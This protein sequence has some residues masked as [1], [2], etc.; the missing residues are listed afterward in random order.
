MLA[1][2][3]PNGTGFAFSR[4]GNYLVSGAED[5]VLLFAVRTCQKIKE[6]IGHKD[7]VQGLTFTPD[8]KTVVSSSS[9]QTI[10]LWDIESGNEIKQFTITQGVPSVVCV[11]NCGKLL[12]AGSN[13]GWVT[14]WNLATGEE[15][16]SFE[17]HKDGVRAL[18]YVCRQEAFLTASID[19][20]LKLWHGET[21]ELIRTFSGHQGAVFVAALSRDAQF[22]V[23][24]S[25]DKTMRLWN[26]MSGQEI[27][28]TIGHIDTVAALALSA[29]GKQLL[30]GSLDRSARLW[31]VESKQQKHVWTGDMEISAVAVHPTQNKAF[32]ASNMDILVYD[33]TN[34]QLLA[35]WSGHQN[36]I[37]AL[38]LSADG[39][40]LYS[41]AWDTYVYQWDVAKGS[42]VRAIKTAASIETVVPV[43]DGQ[44]IAC[45]HWNGFITV[46]ELSSGQQVAGWKG[47]DQVVTGLALNR[48]YLVSTSEDGKLKLWK[49]LDGSLLNSLDLGAIKRLTL[50]PGKETAAM[51]TRDAK[52]ELVALP[53]L[54]KV[55]TLTQSTQP[56]AI[57]V[58]S[59]AQKM[60]VANANGTIYIYGNSK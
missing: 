38:R 56:F 8:G 15:L 17:A 53:A 36:Q 24:G 52:I 50:L 57:A 42:V 59:D 4:D 49:S 20:T 44:N 13:M 33:T 41:A 11:S 6:F 16:K 35:T 47:H 39:A 30:S 51:L 43:A 23:S 9:D 54:E 12:L 22:M 46:W 27:L 7:F 34:G 14:V 25:S 19:G 58:S 45:G 2:N 5:K 10:R 32:V 3:K 40:S 26:M 37:R 55:Q 48:D 18:F 21:Y 31:Q 28:P 29:D 1:Y 60:F